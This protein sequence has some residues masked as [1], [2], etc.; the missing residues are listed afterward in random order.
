MIPG[1]FTDEDVRR[2]RREVQTKIDLGRI[3]IHGDLSLIKDKDEREYQKECRNVYLIYDELK[4]KGFI[5]LT[6]I[7]CGKKEYK[8]GDD[9]QWMKTIDR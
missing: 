9:G 5:P 7:N 3:N 2:T 8:K 4:K 6:T 1:E